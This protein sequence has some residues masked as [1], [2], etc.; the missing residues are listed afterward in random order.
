MHTDRDTLPISQIA[1][2]AEHVY[3]ITIEDDRLVTLG[4]YGNPGDGFGRQV[5]YGSRY[6]GRIYRGE[7]ITDSTN[8]TRPKPT[9]ICA[10][11][12]ATGF[13]Q[14]HSLCRAH[15][16]VAAQRER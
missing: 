6:L 5:F 10:D 3:G 13:S 16:E 2:E 1:A 4:G 12:G 11:L 14:T 8:W 9:C 7:F 15:D